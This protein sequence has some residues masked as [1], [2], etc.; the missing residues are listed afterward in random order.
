MLK[1]TIL[2]TAVASMGAISL[3]ASQQFVRSQA[4]S[5]T[6][7][8]P[9]ASV[10]PTP[11]GAG[12]EAEAAFLRDLHR[13]TCALTGGQHCDPSQPPSDRDAQIDQ[14]RIRYGYRVCQGLQPSGILT[15]GP[16]QPGEI[17]TAEELVRFTVRGDEPMVVSA[18]NNFC[19]EFREAVNAYIGSSQYWQ[20]RKQDSGL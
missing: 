3:V 12:P 4:G 5:P 13:A 17:Q 9:T 8:S 19:P 10:Q 14:R 6:P 11:G 1:N 20:D 18:V 7:A 16:I 2:L 15:E